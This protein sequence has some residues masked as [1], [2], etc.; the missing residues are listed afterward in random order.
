MSPWTSSGENEWTTFGENRWTSLGE[1]G[2][3]TM[4]ENMWTSIARKMTEQD[5][6]LPALGQ[7]LA[8]WARI[9]PVMLMLE[10]LHWAGPATRNLL[11]RLAA[12]L[13]AGGVLVLASYRGEEARSSP[14]T[15]QA[16]RALDR[17]GVHRRLVLARLTA[18]EAGELLRR[19][20]GEP[21]PR[22]EAR[23]Y[24]E[25]AGNSL[26]LL[27]TLRILSGEGR[28]KCDQE[29]QWTTSWD[30]LTEEV[31]LPL[32]A[33]IEKII[34]RRLGSLATSARQVLALA[35]GQVSE[36]LAY[37]YEILDWL[38]RQ[39]VAGIEHPFPVYLTVYRA[40]TAAGKGDRAR[41]VLA[42]AHAL[43]MGR[44]GQIDD[45]ELRHTFLENV[46]EHQ[47]IVAAYRAVASHTALVRLPRTEAPT[48][49][50]LRE[51]ECVPV[52]WTVVAP[53]DEY[54]SASPKRRQAQL[55]RLLGKAADQGAAP[56]VR[57]LAAALSVGEPTVRRDLAT[58]RRAGHPAQPRAVIDRHYRKVGLRLN[59]RDKR[60]TAQ[61]YAAIQKRMPACLWKKSSKCTRTQAKKGKPPPRRQPGSTILGWSKSPLSPDIRLSSAS[62]RRRAVPPGVAGWST[63]GRAKQPA[64]RSWRSCCPSSRAGREVSAHE[65]AETRSRGA[66]THSGHYNTVA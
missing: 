48:G 47:E 6:L 46:A 21:T 53:E 60:E 22:L 28:L 1:N 4:D 7:L 51:E 40:L 54:L 49:R 2:W 37:A 59:T 38:D 11:A 45:E 25:T 20:L 17:T 66:G 27:E 56:T 35:Q 52:T 34:A 9:V 19:T 31:K 43:I 16:L 44:A 64:S 24:A 12:A 5:R 10:D 33:A 3:P 14:E 23:L 18:E 26:F 65:V 42:D 55:Q 41:A 58:L 30:D 63:L 62:G 61:W 36:A 15:W 50:P 29:G 8:G 57:A 32:P 39:G 13:R